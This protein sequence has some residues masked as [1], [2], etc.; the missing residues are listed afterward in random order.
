[1]KRVFLGIGANLI[2]P[3]KMLT[4]AIFQIQNQA[5]KVV[6]VSSYYRSNFEG[7]PWIWGIPLKINLPPV[8]NCVVEVRTCLTPA[9]L[10]RR[11]QRIENNLGRIRLKGTKNLP[12][13]IDIDIL[14]YNDMIIRH[15]M[16]TIPH[17]R[18]HERLFVLVPMAELDSSFIHPVF[19]KSINTLLW[20]L[21]TRGVKNWPVRLK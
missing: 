15:K 9:K 19:K 12:R 17:P 7:H 10:L 20:E 21:K 3:L 5:M 14:F 18:L 2:N 6:A 13:T 16:L 11:I 8:V 1:M 4:R